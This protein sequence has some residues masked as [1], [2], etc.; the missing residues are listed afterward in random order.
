M[1]NFIANFLEQL[2]TG[3]F[4]NLP[5]QIYLMLAILAIFEGPITTLTGAAIASTGALNPALVFISVAGGNLT[6][7]SVWHLLGRLGKINWINR[8]GSLVGVT[9]EQL[10]QLEE[11]AKKH[12]PKALFVT[13]TTSTL[14][15]PTL[16]T[17]GLTRTPWR[18]WFPPVLAGEI[19]WSGSLVLAGYLTAKTIPRVL[20][21][22]QILPII[23]VLGMTVF[24]VYRVYRLRNHGSP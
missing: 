22:I 5:A 11:N 9:P 23:A 12:T 2:Q 16:I 24:I 20:L 17:S 21:G 18:R 3:Q 10:E 6:G 15:I 1:E 19:V 13:K 4:H 14:I 8:F 7:D